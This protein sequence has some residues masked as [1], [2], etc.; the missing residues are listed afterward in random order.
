MMSPTP[1]EAHTQF[2]ADVEEITPVAEV[3]RLLNVDS[4]VGGQIFDRAEEIQ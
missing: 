4:H 3:H 2:H 1:R